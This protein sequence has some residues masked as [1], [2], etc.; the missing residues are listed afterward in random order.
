MSS[1]ISKIRRVVRNPYEKRVKIIHF[2]YHRT[3]TNWFRKIFEQVAGYYGLCCCGVWN[4]PDSNDCDIYIDHHSRS[5]PSSHG[6]FRATH[7]IRDPRDI[8]VSGYFFHRWTNESWANEKNKIYEGHSYKE[9]ITSLSQE[10][11]FLFE[12]DRLQ[13]DVKA[14]VAWDYAQ[15][16][17]L[18]L[19]YEDVVTNEI[20]Q[21]YRMFEHYRFKQSAMKIVEKCVRAN[22]FERVTGRKRG[23]IADKKHLRSGACGDWQEYF[24]P[25]VKEVFKERMGSALIELGYE[26][27]R[28][29]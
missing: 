25:K 24:T 10:D 6:E 16:N 2:C 21:F 26:R 20:D 14:M 22:S 13:E 29:W 8:L 3:G 15:P 23:E 1:I 4:N 12:M 28:D 11:G 17:V 27:N 9:H 5:I 19:R 7:I 18:E